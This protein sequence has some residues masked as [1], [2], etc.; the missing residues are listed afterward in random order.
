MMAV[1]FMMFSFEFYYRLEIIKAYAKGY[2]V[3]YAKPALACIGSAIA[4]YLLA[5]WG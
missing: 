1:A 2:F 3:L 5:R 4:G